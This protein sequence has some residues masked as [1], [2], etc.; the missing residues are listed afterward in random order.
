MRRRPEFIEAV[1]TGSRAGA[2]ALSVHVR[3][4]EAGSGRKIG[5]IVSR[6]VGTAVV[7]N[8]VRRRLRHL[9]RARLEQLPAD[10]AVVVRAH[11]AASLLG[12]AALDAQLDGALT[13]A[14]RPAKAAG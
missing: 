9:M 2:A 14:T 8:R 11:P 6:G 5:F 1:R 12:S 10:V 13:R 4:A 3:A 7:R